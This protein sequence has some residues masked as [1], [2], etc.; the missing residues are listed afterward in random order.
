[1]FG[2][3]VV[4]FCCR[5]VLYIGLLLSLNPLSVPP[6]SLADQTMIVSFLLRSAFLQSV[7]DWGLFCMLCESFGGGS[8]LEFLK[9][10]VVMVVKRKLY[11]TYEVRHGC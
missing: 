6:D 4:G 10:P 9:Y 8:V 7:M 2:W 11:G 3:I 1:M 5:F